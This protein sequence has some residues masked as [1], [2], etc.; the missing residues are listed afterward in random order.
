MGAPAIGRTGTDEFVPP[1]QKTGFGEE[2]D[3]VDHLPLGH[4]EVEEGIFVA[5]RQFQRPLIVEDGIG[6]VVGFVKCVSE[7]VIELE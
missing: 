4:I 5:G 2:V 1:A 3:V 6:D 7:V